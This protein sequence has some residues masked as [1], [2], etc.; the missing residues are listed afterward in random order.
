MPALI[1][2]GKSLAKQTENQLKIRVDNLRESSGKTPVLATIL[3]GND[4]ASETYVKMKG[5]ACQ[6]VGMESL[7][8]FLPKILTLKNFSIKLEN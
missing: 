7:R 2:D 3:V 6:R 8:V 1:L 4:P 5:N